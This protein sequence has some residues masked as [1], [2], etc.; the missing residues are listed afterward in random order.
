MVQYSRYA[1]AL[2]G[3]N[4]SRPPQNWNEEIHLA[5]RQIAGD[6]LMKRKANTLNVVTV[7]YRIT[8]VGEHPINLF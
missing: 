7:M 2:H 8:G 4:W 3:N 1:P 6:V 5:D